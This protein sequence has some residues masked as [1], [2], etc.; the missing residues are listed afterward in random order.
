MLL[1]MDNFSGIIH[2]CV[3]NFGEI[4][5]IIQ[6]FGDFFNTGTFDLSGLSLGLLY[7]SNS[8]YIKYGFPIL[9]S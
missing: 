4:A 5:E 2:K 8:F 1:G 9:H 6:N 3:E 7:S